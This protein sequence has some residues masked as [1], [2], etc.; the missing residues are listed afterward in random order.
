M[1]EALELKAWPPYKQAIRDFLVEF[2]YGDLVPHVWL[3]S[4]FGMPT[5]EDGA[6]LTAEAFRDRQFAWLASVEAFKCELLRDHQVH[7]QSVRGEGYRWV[8]PAEQTSVATKDFER[9]SRKA[10]RSVG[11]RLKNIR[12]SE[13]TDDQRRENMDA[14]AKVS[15]LKGMTRRALR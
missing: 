11:Q 15:A 10:F 12:V 6:R 3:E 9:D 5:I 14:V 13:L 7:L 2:K 1:S 4:H 8:P